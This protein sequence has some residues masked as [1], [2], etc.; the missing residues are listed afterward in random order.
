[1]SSKMMSAATTKA[2]QYILLISTMSGRRAWSRGIGLDTPVLR[3]RRL[4]PLSPHFSRKLMMNIVNRELAHIPKGEKHSL[5]NFLRFAYNALRR[6]HLTLRK[7]RDETLKELVEKIKNAYPEFTP[8]YD[9]D[10][11]QI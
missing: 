9:Q 6:K 3:E 10:Y 8:Q 4:R 5:Q 2:G 1:M 7:T 11:F